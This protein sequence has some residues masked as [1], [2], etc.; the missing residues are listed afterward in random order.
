MGWQYQFAADDRAYGP[1][2]LDAA[3]VAPVPVDAREL[4]GSV[5]VVAEDFPT[6]ESIVAVLESASIGAVG[7]DLAGAQAV[8]TIY[9]PFV[10]L[11]D[12]CSTG[13]D[14]LTLAAR[15]KRHQLEMTV[16]VV[17]DPGVLDTD[18]GS[19]D[20]DGYL[21]KPLVPAA[22]VDTVRE[23]LTQQATARREEELLMP[24]A[25]QPAPA[26]SA[27]R[28]LQPL[29]S[30]LL[31]PTLG[32]LVSEPVQWE[33]PRTSDDLARPVPVMSEV[34]PQPPA[35]ES[36][37][38]WVEPGTF[39]SPYPGGVAVAP[40]VAEPL[41]PDTASDDRA[42]ASAGVSDDLREALLM[43]ERRPAAVFLIQ[44]ELPPTSHVDAIRGM[45]EVLDQAHTMLSGA[46]RKTDIIA[47]SGQDR[48]VVVCPDVDDAPTAEL[49]AS[50][51]AR[52]LAGPLPTA[53][54][55]P[56]LRTS[57]GV[58]LTEI[59]AGNEEVPP[60]DLVEDASVAA[61]R[62][63][64]ENRPWMVF[65]DSWDDATRLQQRL[66]RALD[67]GDLL[68][69]FQKIVNLETHEVIGAEALLRWARPG[70][71]VLPAAQFLDK[72]RE[73][74]LSIPIGRWALGCALAEVCSWRSSGQLAENFRLFVNVGSDELLDPRFAEV[75]E[76]LL[77]ENGLPP[78]VL[79]L[80]ISE[81]DLG[82]AALEPQ[83]E[84]SLRVLSDLG[85]GCI[86][87]DFGTGRSNLTWL[88]RLPVTGIKIDPELVGALDDADSRSGSALVRGLIALAHEMQMK[89]VGE[90]V[91]SL[92][93]ELSLR[94]MGCDMAQGYY[95][96]VP[97]L[98]E[99]VAGTLPS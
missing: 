64:A 5:L 37:A 70:K 34:T 85:V 9:N 88:Q 99:R 25:A 27:L 23:A 97:E 66:R 42:E 94:A 36:E 35:D 22:F 24:L 68:L 96:G 39:G 29:E 3:A 92:S 54:G 48:L 14:G 7:S 43:P 21:V 90:G 40:S 18:R 61:Q 13:A 2:P 4:K 60:E 47:P 6:R 58:V 15:M 62:A 77:R 83:S 73:S 1:I 41:V 19:G 52:D 91:E 59:G 8:Q 49:L 75:V 28:Q 79:T 76:K 93:Q 32:E 67:N 46:R 57:I 56:R 50:G 65:D 51:M 63:L 17:T 72:A 10:A 31:P 71:G 69:N 82:E 55:E 86:V 45:E 87:D 26:E 95:V 78:R 38:W 11:V 33:G 84:R 20:V 80:E 12:F 74:G 30:E 16:L 44:F 81:R 89:V 98:F 53:I